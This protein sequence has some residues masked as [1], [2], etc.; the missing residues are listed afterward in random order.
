MPVYINLSGIKNT[1]NLF[2]TALTAFNGGS[3]ANGIKK[4]NLSV[5]LLIDSYD[6]MR[7]PVNLWN[8]NNFEEW[9][10]TIKII[11]A[12]R[13]DYLVTYT[14]YTTFFVPDEDEN[15]FSDFVISDIDQL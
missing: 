11:V 1:Q 15:A 4:S 10:G 3:Y 14:N 5:V 12:S 9:E 8:Q 2:S 7:Q 6:E 13:G